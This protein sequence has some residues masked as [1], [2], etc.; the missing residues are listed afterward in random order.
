MDHKLQGASA[1]VAD[2]EVFGYNC[3]Q[4][5]LLGELDLPPDQ[6]AGA[7]NKEVFE[8]DV[9]VERAFDTDSST[10]F[11][12]RWFNG[13]AAFAQPLEET[14]G[15]RSKLSSEA[16]DGLLGHPF[17]GRACICVVRPSLYIIEPSVL[18]ANHRVVGVHHVLHALQGIRQIMLPGQGR[19][20]PDFGKHIPADAV[21]AV[22]VV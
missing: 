5:A 2:A 20:A 9:F 3:I 4:T 7:L 21:K 11:C 10:R 19:V 1:R 6:L 8:F 13:F 22:P 15:A 12:Q 16:V 18:F 14:T 17:W